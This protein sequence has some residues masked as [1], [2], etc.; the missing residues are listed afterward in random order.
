MRTVL[1]PRLVDPTAFEPGL[2]VDVRDEKRAL[3]FDLGPPIEAL[4]PRVLL[5]A[6]HAFVTHT[7][8]DHFAGFD[9]LLALGLG[10]VGRL[11]VWGGP[12]FCEQVGHK[13]AAYTW[14]VVHRYEV[15]M[16]IEA[17]ALAP[18]G[19][20]RVARFESR[21]GFA[22]VAATADAPMAAPADAPPGDAR[23]N[24]GAKGAA[25][26]APP[27][28]VHLLLDE[29]LFSVR[30]AFVD[31]EM[32]VLAFA[33]EEKAQLRVAAGR[34]AAMGLATGAWLRTLKA[35]VLAGAADDT[36][37]DLAWR[38]ARGEHAERRSV[39][40][41]KPLVLDTVAGRRIGYVTDLRGTPDNVERLAALLAGC[42]LLYIESV[43]S[44]ADREQ[45]RRKNHLTAGD[46]GAIARRLGAGQV[47]PFHFSPRYRGGEERLREEVAAA[48]RG[49]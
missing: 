41:L 18:D 37:V 45:A 24:P 29:P 46:A 14:N 16:T 31:H 7:H 6:T 25:G 21:D 19:S 36:P 5:R 43:F 32:P 9:H 23:A 48:W 1:E 13:L 20:R 34:L 39:G 33:I 22:P 44:D 38:D 26:A 17:H 30:A 28:G 47:V 40:E 15:P 49:A 27:D 12:G 35:L 3:L 11:V 2:V 8:M 10:R 42:D 4:P